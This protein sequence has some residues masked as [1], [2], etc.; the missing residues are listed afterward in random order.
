MN[1]KIFKIVAYTSGCIG[2]TSLF[3]KFWYSKSNRNDLDD[4]SRMLTNEE[5]EIISD[6]W[7]DII[8]EIFPLLKDQLKII[9]EQMQKLNPEDFT[10]FKANFNE[11]SRIIS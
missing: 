1:T 8:I 6:I 3:Y 9:K 5:T 7:D 11:N 10:K 4:E 2:L